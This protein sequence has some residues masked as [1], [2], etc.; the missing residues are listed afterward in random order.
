MDQDRERE[1]ELE[2]EKLRRK[3]EQQKSATVAIPILLDDNDEKGEA[4]NTPFWRTSLF[5][6]SVVVAVVGIFCLLWTRILYPNDDTKDP[7]PSPDRTTAMD[8]IANQRMLSTFH[9]YLEST[10]LAH[11]IRNDNQQ[12]T[13][14]GSFTILAPT[15]DAFRTFLPSELRYREPKGVLLLRGLLSKHIIYDIHMPRDMTN[16]TVLNTLQNESITVI[17]A[18]NISFLLR[19]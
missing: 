5:G 8:I 17:S 6:W 9:M 14:N 4:R 11:Y 3:V 15:N 13:R 19:P 10:G 12:V 18:P 7:V 2:N 1:L 16:G